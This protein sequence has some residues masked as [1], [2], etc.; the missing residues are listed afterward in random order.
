MQNQ[1]QRSP[2]RLDLVPNDLLTPEELFA[3]T[4]YEESRYQAK[5]LSENNIFFLTVRKGEIRTTWYHVNNPIH[6]RVPHIAPTTSGIGW[7]KSFKPRVDSVPGPH[8]TDLE[9]ELSV[10]TEPKA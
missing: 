3:L 1:Q 2:L 6:L 5:T 4:G 8:N 9:D 10:Y 7:N